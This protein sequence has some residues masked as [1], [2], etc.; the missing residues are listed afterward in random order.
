MNTIEINWTVITYCV[1][2]LFALSGLFKGWWKE[3]ITAFLLGILVFLL[4]MPDVAQIVIDW[5]NRVLQTIWG[6][7]PE[8]FQELLTNTLGITSL[9]IDAGS[10]QTWLVILILMLGFSILI[11]R[12]LLPNRIR[13]AK[14]YHT[15]AVTPLGS[16][17]GGLLGGLN[18]FLIIN[19]V[20]E[21]LDGS[22]LPSG[23]GEPATTEVAVAGGQTAGIASSGVGFEVTDLPGFTNM[24]S[25]LGWIVIGFI[26]LLMVYVLRS[27]MA[28][29]KQPPGYVRGEITREV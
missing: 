5:L 7:L 22:S 10:G 14:S 9:Q 11:G 19:L 28:G 17:L 16:F 27:R 20:R 12:L 18:G 21:Y 4:R 25:F 8:S 29:A 26:L 1:I 24:S 2:G 15:Y 23:P 3:A 6:W 13:T